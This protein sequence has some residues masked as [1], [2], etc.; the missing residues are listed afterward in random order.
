M[1]LSFL[2]IEQDN[3]YLFERL[4]HFSFSKKYNCGIGAR[5]APKII[6]QVVQY[7]LYYAWLV[8]IPK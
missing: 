4:G 6:K 3:N 1:F 5:K 7:N 8:L 2:H